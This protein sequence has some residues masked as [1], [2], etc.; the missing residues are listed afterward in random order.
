M[1]VVLVDFLCGG[2]DDGGGCVICGSV[3]GLLLSS[4][5]DVLLFVCVSS[6][7]VVFGSVFVGERVFGSASAIGTVFC[8]VWSVLIS[9][10]MVVGEGFGVGD[11]D[12]AVGIVD[13]V[14]YPSLCFSYCLIMLSLHKPEAVLKKFKELLICSLYLPVTIFNVFFALRAII[15]DLFH[16]P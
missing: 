9:S 6:N 7:K 4:F 14:A 8:S 2:A 13:C 16:D 3:C 1:V 5:V 10:M 11:I 15:M 12:K